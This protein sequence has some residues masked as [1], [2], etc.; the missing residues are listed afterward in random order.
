MPGYFKIL[1]S[2]LSGASLILAILNGISAFADRKVK[3][4]A[5]LLSISSLFVSIYSFSNI[6]LY[7]SLTAGDFMSANRIDMFCTAIIIICLLT[8]IRRYTGLGQK[9][10]Y[11][12]LVLYFSIL[13]FLRLTSPTTLTYKAVR[14]LRT[15]TLIWGEQLSLIDADISLFGMVYFLVA[16]FS[17]FYMTVQAMGFWRRERSLRAVFLVAGTSLLTLTCL[18]DIF[19]DSFNLRWVYLLEFGYTGILLFMTV[20]LFH[21]LLEVPVIRDSLVKSRQVQKETEEKLQI[22]EQAYKEIF[23]SSKDA[24]IVYDSFSG[25]ILDVNESMEQLFH[26]RRE[27]ILG[28]TMDRFH[29]GEVPYNSEQFG[30][31]LDEA[32]A[33]GS[34]LFEWPFINNEGSLFWTEINLKQS[35]NRNPG[36]VIAVV[37]DVTERKATLDLLIQ[38][39]KMMSLGGL[40]AGMAHEINN[41]LAGIVQTVNVMK[42]RLIEKTDTSANLQAAR[43]SG[44]EIRAIQSYMEMRNIPG[45]MSSIVESAKRISGIIENM[46]SFSRKSENRAVQCS[47]EELMEKTLG[48]IVTDYD[49]KKKYDFK[50]ISMHR[51]FDSSVPPVICVPGEIQQ[52]FVNILRNAAQAMHEHRTETPAIYLRTA[53]E[54]DK[55]MVSME[56][57]DNG[58]GMPDEVKKRIFEPF[59]TT[60]TGNNGTGLG[61]SVSYYII[62][63]N[64]KGD[65]T[66]DSSPGRGTKFT[67]LLPGAD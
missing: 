15:S 49:L 33:K 42:N 1:L 30:V 35:R 17:L 23:N 67:I 51:E 29:S 44:T 66:V 36:K 26:C 7:S 39:E 53:Y 43:D 6:R 22:K 18:N 2:M 24:I 47:L 13:P 31:Y 32:V 57:E 52:V 12:F 19:V 27:D 64:H 50:Q 60:R 62:R 9:G 11:I 8:Y 58:P 10:F 40:A 38:S 34:I 56:I 48:L 21:D 63:E 16:L 65:M 37:R 14:G 46:L 41:P 3:Y 20:S 61:L 28:F 54:G 59:F 5:M 55:N 45:M 4:N 25:I